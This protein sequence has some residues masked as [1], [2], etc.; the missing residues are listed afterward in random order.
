EN[1][2][3]VLHRYQID[4]IV[5][6]PYERSVFALQDSS[7]GKAGALDLDIFGT[8]V[9]DIGKYQIYETQKSND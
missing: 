9:Y 2:D 3:E 4:Y 5:L 7:S 8:L 6:G 1:F